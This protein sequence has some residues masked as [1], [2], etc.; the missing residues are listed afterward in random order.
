[1][2]AVIRRYQYLH[3]N[4]RLLVII[5]TV[6]QSHDLFEPRIKSRSTRDDVTGPR[7]PEISQVAAVLDD[8]RF[9]GGSLSSW[10]NINDTEFGGRT[11]ELEAINQLV[12]SIVQ[13]DLDWSAGS[14]LKQKCFSIYRQDVATAKV[15]AELYK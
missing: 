1:M 4:Y 7:H 9:T 13:P 14:H 11:G 8:G 6:C 5:P 12:A 2:S 3:R 10:L 15:R